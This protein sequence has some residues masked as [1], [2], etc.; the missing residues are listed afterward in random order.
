[1][2]WILAMS[3]LDE[4]SI[5]SRSSLWYGIQSEENFNKGGFSGWSSTS[6]ITPKL[7]FVTKEDFNLAQNLALPI[8]GTVITKLGLDDV[9][10]RINQGKS[11]NTVLYRNN[12]ESWVDAPQVMNML[13][14]VQVVLEAAPMAEG[15]LKSISPKKAI[16]TVNSFSKKIAKFKKDN[17][18]KAQIISVFL[19]VALLTADLTCGKNVACKTSF[20]N[21]AKTK[22]LLEKIYSLQTFVLSGKPDDETTYTAKDYQIESIKAIAEFKTI[23]SG[24]GYGKKGKRRKARFYRFLRAVLLSEFVIQPI[25]RKATG[26][27]IEQ[28]K[29]YKLARGLLLKSKTKKKKFKKYFSLATKKGAVDPRRLL[30]VSLYSIK[31]TLN[32]W[33]SFTN[34]ADNIKKISAKDVVSAILI[35]AAMS[36][37]TAI[38]QSVFNLIKNLTPAKYF[39]LLMTG[40]KAGAMVY[41]WLTDPTLVRLS[42]K[43]TDK[44]LD[45]THTLPD[46]KAIRYLNIPPYNNKLID[47]SIPGGMRSGKTVWTGNEKKLFALGTGT[48]DNHFLVMSGFKSSLENQTAFKKDDKSQVTGLMENKKINMLWH[49]KQF[50]LGSS[51]QPVLLGER[52]LKTAFNSNFVN[53]PLANTFL[54]FTNA[55]VNTHTNNPVQK[56]VLNTKIR[57]YE[58]LDFTAFYKNETG[59]GSDYPLSHVTPGIYFDYTHISF[60]TSQ[61]EKVFTNT[62]NMYVLPDFT[63]YADRLQTR[64]KY[65]KGVNGLDSELQLTFRASSNWNKVAPKGLWMVLEYPLNGKYH[66]TTPIEILNLPTSGMPVKS[67][68]IPANVDLATVKVFIYNEII[69]TY[70]QKTGKSVVNVLHSTLV[71]IRDN[72]DAPLIYLD[73]SKMEE[74]KK[75][76]L[77]VEDLDNDG[78]ADIFDDFPEDARYQFDSDEDGI[79]DSWEI[80]YSLDEDNA[81]DANIDSDNDGLS[82]LEEFRQDSN[83]KESLITPISDLNVVA[84]NTQAI[85]TWGAIDG[86]AIYNLYYATTPDGSEG[87]Q[88]IENAISPYTVR[89]LTNGTTYYLA[90]TSEDIGGGES[91]Q[92]NI[93]S[94]TPTD[95]TQVISTG[96]LNDTG[97]TWGANYPSGNNTTCVGKQITAQDCSHGRDA[98]AMAGTLAKIGAGAGG[99]DFTKLDASGNPLSASATSWSCV[100]DNHTGLIWEVKTTDGGIHDNDNTYKWGGKTAIGK[101]AT[102]PYGTYYDDWDVLVDGS[103]SESLCGYSD[104][105]VPNIT[106]LKSIVHL[107]VFNPAIDTEYFPNTDARGYWSSSPYANY[108]NY[109]WGVYFNY[110]DDD[111]YNRNVTSSLRLVRS[112]Q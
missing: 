92:S 49:V 67:Y 88:K 13:S 107:G 111:D 78:M 19:D 39:D 10:T 84:G 99:F 90:T 7:G 64:A 8:Y 54:W 96:K 103:N 74:T 79:A 80:R 58:T 43:K 50:P 18:D 97:I 55:I 52:T 17:E 1:M 29:A 91:E 38:N 36:A 27:E 47:Q 20:S 21:V 32:T 31:E 102:I 46:L 33:T 4:L 22:D 59:N 9:D 53:E 112:G 68:P 82:N 93:V 61:E 95:I 69:D 57:D 14:V 83:P 71:Y 101:N 76:L 24:K 98:Q 62:I 5:Y 48:E 35:D 15:L 16:K 75:S 66:R 44:L 108:S 87:Y 86:A 73:V 51:V 77:I 56:S 45:V 70:I 109:A 72:E 23:I 85:A 12:P 30:N 40:N 6:L 25:V 42:M 63:F 65:F 81:A 105:R 60:K 37:N 94:V 110:G 11:I 26:K 34:F 89:G 41:D 2:V 28:L 104:W 3:S 106:E 100:K